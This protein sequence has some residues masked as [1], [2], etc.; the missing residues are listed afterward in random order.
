MDTSTRGIRNNN[1]CNI[2]LG[3]HWLGLVLEQTD[4]S[5]CQFIEPAYGIRA[6]AKILQ[7]YEAIGLDTVRQMIERWAPPSDHNP[8]EA[9]I[10]QVA[11]GCGVTPDSVIDL[12]DH[13][14]SIIKC[15]LIQENGINPYTDQQ[16]LDGLAIP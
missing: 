14:F 4:K 6:C 15:I 1:P 2:R 9:Y 3:Q 11:K 16:I 8:T 7:H 5:F 10:N 13:L 12:E